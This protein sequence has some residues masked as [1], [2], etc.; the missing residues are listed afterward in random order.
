MPRENLPKLKEKL[1]NYLKEIPEISRTQL[2]R[3]D[4][5]LPAKEIT[6]RLAKSLEHLGPFG[7]GNEKPIFKFTQLKLESYN[8]MKDIHVRWNF[9]GGG[10]KLK[11]IS[12]NYLNNNQKIHPEEIFNQQGKRDND[13]IVYGSLGINR[14]KGQEFIQIMVEEIALTPFQ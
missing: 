12:F 2:R 10:I 5:D 8:V 1:N 3:V 9:S 6:P 13:L 14:W 4:L 7:I 11:G